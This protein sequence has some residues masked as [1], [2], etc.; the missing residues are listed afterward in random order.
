MDTD[1]FAELTTVVGFNAE[2]TGAYE[3][4]DHGGNGKE[5]QLPEIVG[6][7]EEYKGGEEKDGGGNAD[8]HAKHLEYWGDGKAVTCYFY[9]GEQGNVFYAHFV[10]VIGVFDAV[11]NGVHV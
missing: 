6:V 7:V 10:I 1:D 2:D 4:H 8:T 11:L 3:K 9:P 5:G